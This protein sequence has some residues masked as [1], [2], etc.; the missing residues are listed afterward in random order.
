MACCLDEAGSSI[1]G[2]LVSTKAG[3]RGEKRGGREEGG[4]EGKGGGECWRNVSMCCARIRDPNVLEQKEHCN[5]RAGAVVGG[6]GKATYSSIVTVQL[7]SITF[8]SAATPTSVIWLLPR[9]DR[10]ER[11]GEKERRRKGG[12]GGVG[13]LEERQH[14]CLYNAGKQ[15]AVRVRVRGCASRCRGGELG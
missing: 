10:E 3:W 4:K 2:D 15:C 11:R 6:S 13:V 7:P 8:A 5:E 14:V 9:L 1:F 12:K